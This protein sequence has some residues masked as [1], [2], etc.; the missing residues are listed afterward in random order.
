MHSTLMAG[1]IL[2]TI[3][4]CGSLLVFSGTVSAQ[5]KIKTGFLD[6]PPY[7]VVK[8]TGV[9]GVMVDKIKNTLHQAGFDYEMIGYP[10]KRL[11]AS[12]NSGRIDLLIG[13]R[14]PHQPYKDHALYS[15]LPFMQMVMKIYTRN[16]LNIP[17]DLKNLKGKVG[18]ISG[19][20]YGGIIDKNNPQTHEVN[21]HDSAFKML[22]IGRLDY[23]L[24]YALP[25]E[26]AI[27]ANKIKD[28]KSRT[29]FKVDLFFCLRKDFPDADNV[30][31]AIETAYQ[32]RP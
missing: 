4:V 16:E 24:D 19:Y 27:K 26:T 21:S 20:R 1:S 31:K 13:T 11:F 9:S 8:G 25:A 15:A 18:L 14:G 23:V 32:S 30:M 7:A 6:F 28:L 2:K 29:I 5:T 10:P 22:D 3:L 12:F 17:E